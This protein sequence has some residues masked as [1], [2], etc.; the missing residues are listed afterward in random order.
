MQL[1][2]G[3]PVLA[4]LDCLTVCVGH[5][6]AI[7][8]LACGGRRTIAHAIFE[9]RA[10]PTTSIR[11]CHLPCRSYGATVVALT[12]LHV[13]FS[14]TCKAIGPVFTVAL[15]SRFY[16][17]SYDRMVYLSLVPIVGGVMLSTFQE[18]KTFDVFGP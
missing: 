8:W 10:Q 13:S 18:G 17:A 14:H 9:Q 12:R 1:G 11:P 2:D 15:A 7:A 6:G 5:A 3:K 4:L 16:G